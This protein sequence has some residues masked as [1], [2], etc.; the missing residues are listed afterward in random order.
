MFVLVVGVSTDLLLLTAHHNISIAG[1]IVA[2]IASVVKLLVA[3]LVVL[4]QL[5]VLIGHAITRREDVR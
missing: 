4:G 1:A 3:I 2:L 5:A